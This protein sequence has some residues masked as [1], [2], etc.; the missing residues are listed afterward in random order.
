[1]AQDISTVRNMN[2]NKVLIILRRLA[3]RNARLK[4]APSRESRCVKTPGY[5]VYV[6]G[7]QAY[8]ER[9]PA[10][11]V[12]E[13]LSAGLIEPCNDGYQITQA[14]LCW[15]KRR[16]SSTDNF[17]AQHQTRYLRVIDVEGMKR[18]AVVNDAEN[19]LRWLASRK[20]KGGAPLLSPFQVEAGER[21]RADYQFAG[22]SAR[23]TASWSP[24]AQSGAS[25]GTP[26]DA[27]A[28]QD[29]VLAARQRVVQA[30]AAVG[31]E[32]CGILVDVCCHLKGLEDAEKA[33]GWPQRS[34]KVVLQIALTRLARHYG[35]ISDDQ[36]NERVRRKLQHWGA[37]DYRPE[38][39]GREAAS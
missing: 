2:D 20:G 18:A 8:A 25:A 6:D 7:R 15:L 34:G 19:P 29:N 4:P 10:E 30:L 17:Q 21:L 39:G 14:G 32:L 31:P 23:V 33:E 37:D 5:V 16:L 28:M 24:A 26:G 35:L 1:M 9:V 3:K 11:S 12:Q 27:S 38:I 13:W 36:L 22:L